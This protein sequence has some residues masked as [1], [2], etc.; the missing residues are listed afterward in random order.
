MKILFKLFSRKDFAAILSHKPSSHKLSVT[1]RPQLA[2][3]N[4]EDQ[5][6]R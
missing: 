1:F 4:C 2:S 3:N 5:R 6:N